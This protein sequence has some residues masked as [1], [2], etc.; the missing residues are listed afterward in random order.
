MLIL[1]QQINVV[2]ILKMITRQT[3]E[4]KKKTAVNQKEAKIQ[5]LTNLLK[6]V[7]A[8]FEKYKKRVE[9]DKKQSITTRTSK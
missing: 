3:I 8:D 7:Q 2:N 4:Q 1:N 6:K 5:E 9:K